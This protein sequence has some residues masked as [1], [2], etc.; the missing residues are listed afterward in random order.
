MT[1]YSW[2]LSIL[3]TGQFPRRA[4]CRETQELSST[5]FVGRSVGYKSRL[6]VV[7]VAPHFCRQR[8]GHSREE[9]LANIQDYGVFSEKL[10]RESLK[11]TKHMSLSSTRKYVPSRAAVALLRS[12]AMHRRSSVN[13]SREHSPH[14]SFDLS[15]P[16]PP[17]ASPTALCTPHSPLLGQTTRFS[18]CLAGRRKGAPWRSVGT[19]MRTARDGAR[20][21]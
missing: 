9:M 3:R 15:T 19:M 17:P 16:R 10:R 11:T 21:R 18:A 2:R 5:T 7:Y 12:C 1:V 13:C 8:G 6:V 14:S 20:R 4:G